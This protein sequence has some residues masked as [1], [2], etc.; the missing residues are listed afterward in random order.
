MKDHFKRHFYE[1]SIEL[2]LPFT[3]QWKNLD[4]PITTD[5]V[6]RAT[7]KLNNSRTA[8]PDRISAELSKYAP[9]EVHV[10]IHKLFLNHVLENYQMFNIGRG[11]LCPL[12]KLG[13]PKGPVKNLIP[14]ILLNMLRKIISMI[15]LK[16][17]KPKYEEYI[18]QSQRTYRSNH[19]ANDVVWAHRWIIAKIQIEETEVNITSINM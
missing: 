6:R 16:R 2:F 1:Q 10:F 12:Y 18:S 8:G 15:L 11:L 19:S 3:G 5:E 14:V 7:L 17:V 9:V 13:K 4:K